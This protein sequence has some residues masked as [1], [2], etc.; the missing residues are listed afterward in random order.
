LA[1]CAEV[2][3]AGPQPRIDPGF[4]GV[5]GPTASSGYWSAS[6]FATNPNFAWDAVFGNGIVNGDHKTFVAVFFVRAVRAGSCSS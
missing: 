1:T 4:A 2:L 6:S 5:G 3:A